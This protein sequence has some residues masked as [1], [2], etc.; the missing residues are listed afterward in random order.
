MKRTIFLIS[1]LFGANV[2]CM[3]SAH[4]MD[5]QKVKKYSITALKVAGCV[6][7]AAAI[8]YKWKQVGATYCNPAAM[9]E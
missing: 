2:L 4:A 6:A 1:L 3:G 7:V 8:V 5:W 9:Y